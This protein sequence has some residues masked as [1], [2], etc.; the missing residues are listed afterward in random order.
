VSLVA[1]VGDEAYVALDKG[2]IG[3]TH[4]LV[5]PIEHY[6]SMLTLPPA[7]GD[8]V[9]RYL[10]SLRA[11]YA[12]KGLQLVGFER[13]LALRSKGGNHCH[14]EAGAGGAAGAWMPPQLGSG[15][16][17]AVSSL[18]AALAAP[19]PHPQQS[20]LPP[21]AGAPHP[22]TPAPPRPAPPRPAPPCPAPPRPAP[23][24]PAPPR[25]APAVNVIGVDPEA[26]SDARRAFE[27]VAGAAGF[28]LTH[29]PPKGGGLDRC[30]AAAFGRALDWGVLG[31]AWRREAASWAASP[32]PAVPPPPP[33]TPRT[34]LPS[35]HTHPPLPL[36][37]P[38]TAR[39]PRAKLQQLAGSGEYF[40]GVLPDG[41]ALIRPIRR[42]ERLPMD[43]GRKIL[44]A[45]SGA[46]ERADWRA[47]AKAG[48]EEEEAE[49][50]RFKAMYRPFDIFGGGGGGGE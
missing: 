4:A 24:R 38:N 9:A 35:P 37:T 44:A 25:P 15:R 2:Q 21:G 18:H 46:P 12:S 8:E 11:A 34:D 6:P 49:A 45:L 30:A 19:R 3:P 39:T 10:S 26:G 50:E 40:L 31:S 20:D 29:V 42:G 7:C 41:G 22:P 16:A 47:C 13:H 5:V 23:P 43:L 27:E 17:A 32:T 28:D 48:P 1:S 33:P 14:S 36:P